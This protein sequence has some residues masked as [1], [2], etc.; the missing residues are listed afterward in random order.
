MKSTLLC[1]FIIIGF[2]SKPYAFT[3]TPTPL[4]MESNH[5]LI[6][7]KGKKT[8]Q[9]SFKHIR[10]ATEKRLGRKL[11]LNERIGLWYYTK[12]TEPDV[13][14]KKAN[15][16]ALIGF[17]FGICSIVL[18]PLLAIPGFF[19]S[20]SALTQEKLQPGILEGGNKGL[21]KAGLILSI[22]GFVYLLL[23]IAYFAI[24]IASFGI[25]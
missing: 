24:I 2:V 22:I 23:I 10:K 18:L 4:A 20:Q 12:L 1:F 21:A 9:T 8:S 11:K 19:L 16:H 6:E 25:R 5:Q 17:I 14:G 15:N 13:D 7:N 3:G